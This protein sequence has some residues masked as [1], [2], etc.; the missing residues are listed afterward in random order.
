MELKEKLAQALEQEFERLKDHSN[1]GAKKQK[2]EY[3]LAINYLRTGEHPSYYD[4][5][6][7]LYACI[8]D[9]ETMCK[10]YLD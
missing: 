4:D 6:D 1:F 10:D 7:L 2:R 9:F 3:D 8:E 5:N